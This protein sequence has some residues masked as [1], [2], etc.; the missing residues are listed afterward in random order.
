MSR[1]V[2]ALN[3]KP[4]SMKWIVL[5][6]VVCIVPY[7]WITLKYRKEA[8][9]HQPYQ[10]NKDRA[11]VMRLLDAGFQRIHVSL[12]RLVDPPAPLKDAATIAVAPGGIPP[13]L[14]ELLIDKPPV[15]STF[16]Q[17]NAPTAALSGASYVITLGC[18]QP[19]HHEQPAAS[20]AYRRG[21]EV[22]FVIGY[23][24]NPGELLSRHTDAFLRL[25][26]PA[27][28]FEPGQY[29][30]TLIGA[31]ASRRWTFTVH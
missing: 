23:E 5:A 31:Q 16:T 11:Q 29:H 22:N 9:P 10:D 13:I 3:R 4:W 15:P 6:I 27:H 24:T 21:Q 8:P 7:T 28:A 2:P 25:V 18:T 19:D 1:H 20:V 30:A 12:E 26:V 17:V 14:S